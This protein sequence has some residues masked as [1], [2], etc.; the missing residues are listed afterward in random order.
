V[1][2][3]EIV[4]MESPSPLNPLGIKGA[5]EAGTIPA[6]SAIISAIENALVPFGVRIQRAPVTAEHLVELIE[7]AK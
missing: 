7:A 1:P 5:G 2:K 4:S 6:A 3:V